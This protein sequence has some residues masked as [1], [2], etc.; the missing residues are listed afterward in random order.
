MKGQ[1]FLTRNYLMLQNGSFE[2]GTGA[3]REA[4]LGS[5]PAA[6]CKPNAEKQERSNWPSGRS[7]DGAL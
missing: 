4:I 6:E 7:F 2:V 5:P 1:A 3:H